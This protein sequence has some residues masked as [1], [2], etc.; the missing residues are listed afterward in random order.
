[1][2]HMDRVWR[3]SRIIQLLALLA[4]LGT[5]TQIVGRQ[6][7]K[8]IGNE[9][10]VSVDPLPEAGGEI[11]ESV[12]AA[13]PGHREAILM[14]ALEQSA[15][16]RAASLEARNAPTQDRSKLKPVR[17]IHDPY[18][19]F[20]SVAVDPINNEVV[21]TDENLF[22]IMVYNRTTTTPPSAR[23]TEPKRIIAGLKTKI[24]FQCGLYIDPKTGNIYAVNNDTVDTLVIFDRNAKGDVPPTRELHTP[25]GTFGIAVDEASEEM[26][27]TLQHDSAMVVFRKYAEKDESPLR[28]LQGEATGLAD[29]HGIALDS[30][31]GWV[32]IANHGAVSS[33]A[34]RPDARASRR[35]GQKQNW[36]L[37]RASAVPGS[38]RSLPPSIIVHSMK[39]QG[40]VS[41]LRVIQG[42]KTQFDW[43]TGLAIDEQRGE[44]YVANDIGN[45]ILVVNVNDSGDVAPKRVI[46]GPKTNLRN[47][48]GV[49]VDLKNNE[50][51]AANFMNHSATVYP[52]NASGDVAPLRIIRS[53]PM[54]EPSLGIGNPHPVAYDSKREQILVPN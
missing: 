47:P 34:A 45:S 48:T 25:H 3:T 15:E 8:V 49:W 43:P 53:G 12:P 37:E 39:A 17:W 9:R 35:A 31:N 42:P 28:L 7:P 19:A 14:A 13:D 54:N 32:F 40:N 44:L 4:L 2:A 26:F 24:E 20:S 18:A 29:P 6:Q 16:A 30:K 50:V 10:L 46:Q 33:R 5:A 36:P 52:L 11:C 1:M 38:G 23:L 22:Q 41:P 21:M 27:L 51:W